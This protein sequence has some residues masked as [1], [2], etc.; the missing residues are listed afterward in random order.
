[1]AKKVASSAF[2]AMGAVSSFVGGWFFSSHAN[3]KAKE[4]FAPPTSYADFLG[5]FLM[6]LGVILGVLAAKFW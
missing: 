5:V 4:P 1:M 6:V 3:L 2:L